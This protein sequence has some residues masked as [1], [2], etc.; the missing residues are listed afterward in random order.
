[1]NVAGEN[2]VGVIEDSLCLISENNLNLGARFTDE[3]AVIFDIV[4]AGKLMNVFAEKLAV[5]F[6]RENV[7]I[8][9]Y[10]RLV[11]LV[12]AYKLVSNLVGGVKMELQESELNLIVY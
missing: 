2:A 7:G 8:G 9:V 6:K 10:A 12:E 5:T 4:N 11:K 1:M 3:V